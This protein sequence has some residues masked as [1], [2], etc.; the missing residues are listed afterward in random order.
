MYSF[1]RRAGQL[2]S[3][4]SDPTGPS[5]SAASVQPG[6]GQSDTAAPGGNA[7]GGAGAAAAPAARRGCE[8]YERQ[9]SIVAP[10]CGRGYP[11]RL[12]HDAN[13]DHKVDR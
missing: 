7:A 13:E 11:C 4:P 1:C 10:C 12:C 5:D 3:T 8:H 2:V 9:C 6:G